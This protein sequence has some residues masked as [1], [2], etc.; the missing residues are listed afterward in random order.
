VGLGQRRRIGCKGSLH[1]Q[2]GVQGTHRVIFTGQRGAKEGREPVPHH[3]THKPLD[4]VHLGHQQGQ[5]AG[6]HVVHRLG[7][8]LRV[9]C[10][11]PIEAGVAGEQVAL[12][13]Q[14]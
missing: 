5:A 8:S 14:S 6:Q 9:S 1:A 7:G 4:P 11:L 3:L 2:G 12:A 13:L 10:L